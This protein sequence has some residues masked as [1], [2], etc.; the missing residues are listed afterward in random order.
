ERTSRS[1]EMESPGHSNARP[2][3][4]K[5]E[6]EN[7]LAPRRER[8][9]VLRSDFPTFGP[10]HWLAGSLALRAGI[11]I[12]EAERHENGRGPTRRRGLAAMDFWA[13]KWIK[14]PLGSGE[15]FCRSAI[16]RC[17]GDDGRE[18]DRAATTSEANADDRT[19]LAL[20][21]MGFLFQF[22]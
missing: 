17:S 21:L 11:E 22:G 3:C 8:F 7:R 20:V 12:S 16:L 1:C 19:P 13:K 4:E 2:G 15:P 14:Q 18:T 5:N 9:F 10:F 6:L